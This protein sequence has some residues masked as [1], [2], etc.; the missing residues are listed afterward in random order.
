MRRRVSI[1]FF[2]S[3][4][5][6]YI[7]YN[8]RERDMQNGHTHYDLE[9][10]RQDLKQYVICHYNYAI[11]LFQMSIFT[12]KP[13][14][15]RRCCFSKNYVQTLTLSHHIHTDVYTS[16][17]INIC[18]FISSGTLLCDNEKK[19]VYSFFLSSTVFSID[20]ILYQYKIENWQY[21]FNILEWKYL[22]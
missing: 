22:Q 16:I 21:I 8:Y 6:I 1:V 4:R 17:D 2:N 15:R 14:C 5:Q 12:E 11:I 18:S 9:L 3:K 13:N 19:F 7:F 10:A 20:F